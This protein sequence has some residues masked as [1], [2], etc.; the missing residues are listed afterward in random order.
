MFWHIIVLSILL[1]CMNAFDIPARQ[2]FVVEMVEN[3]EDL[4]NAIALNSMIFNSA[5]LVGPSVAGILIATTG[6]GVCFLLNGISFLFVII[7]LLLMR[8]H[9]GGVPIRNAGM[10]KSLREGFVY[11]FGSESIRSIIFL[12]V[13]VSL[14]GIPYTVL[15]PVFAKDVLGGGSHTFGFLMGGS[16]IGALSGALYLAARKG[17]LGL[18]RKIPL[19]AGI[20]GL[21]LVLFSFSR[22]IWLSICLMILTGLGMMVQLASSNTIIQT[23]VADD[24]RG[25]VMSIYAM[26]LMGTAPIGS[27]LAGALASSIGAPATILSGGIICITGAMIFAHRIKN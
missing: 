23:I 1:G 27:F 15:I 7:S 11:T 12:I 14:V 17:I 2:A 16:G 6:E 21:G 10:F 24:K 3:R 19:S 26:S 22:L 8:V 4:G 25:R 13:L 5:R 18:E 9:S 20:F